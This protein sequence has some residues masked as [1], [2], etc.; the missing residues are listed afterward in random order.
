MTMPPPQSPGSY[1]P[2]QPPP[3]HGGQQYAPRPGQPPYPPQAYPPQ[4]WPGHGGWAQPP[5][6]P[7]PR[8]R[9]TGLVVGIVAGSLAG[10]CLIGFSVNALMDAQDVASGSG[11]PEARYR[12]TVPQTMLDGRFTLAQDLSQTQ[13]K[14]ALDGTYDPKIRAPKP[15]VGQYTAGSAEEL[16]A[17]VLSGMY[18]Q[19]KDPASARRK[20]MDGAA[21]S[22]GATL[23]VPAR[24][25]TP[26][27]SGITVTCQVLT[28]SQDGATT[29][30]PMCAWADEN[31][32]AS[33]AVVTPETARQSPGSV[34]LDKIAATTL[35][36]REE[37]RRPL[38]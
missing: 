9:R 8:K 31:T 1:G 37:A 12:L 7:P 36:V 17:L 3:P 30:L 23:A 10:L 2:P 28:S 14:A 6:A 19:F 11:F 24:E 16:S 13:G 25:I 15:A 21:E 33:V 29:T 26:A 32:G 5:M 34:D 27:G 4:P 22:Q 35:Q 20:M 18:G 38:G